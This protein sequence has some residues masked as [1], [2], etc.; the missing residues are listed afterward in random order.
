MLDIIPPPEVIKQVWDYLDEDTADRKSLAMA[1]AIV[2]SEA[3]RL[4]GL[5]VSCAGWSRAMAE[6]QNVTREMGELRTLA[7]DDTWLHFYQN[8]VR[9]LCKLC[10][11]LRQ[12]DMGPNQ[13]RAKIEQIQHL[14]R[15]MLKETWESTNISEMDPYPIRVRHLPRG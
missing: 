2:T 10:S 15:V 3:F 11:E 12:V 5:K 9:R 8:L 4:G 14:A 7:D 13:T 6:F 1:E